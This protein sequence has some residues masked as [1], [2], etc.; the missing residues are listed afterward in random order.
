MNKKRIKLFRLLTVLMSLAMLL[1]SSSMTVLA[2][3]VG[4]F[5]DDSEEIVINPL[6]YSYGNL[7]Y[8]LDENGNAVITGNTLTEDTDLTIPSKIDGHNVVSIGGSAF[9]SCE[10][11]T[12]IT[13]PEGVTSIGEG[14]F[15]SCE[16]LTSINLPEGVTRIE[17]FT[18]A[19]CESLTSISMPDSVESIGDYAFQYCT[20]LTSINLPEGV[21]S[22]GDFAFQGCTNLTSINLPKRVTSIGDYAFYSC[23]SL[24]SINLPE[25]VTRIEGFTFADCESLKS[26]SMPDSVESIGDYAFQNCNSLTSITISEG[27]TSIGYYAFY[28]CKSLTSI[29][30]PEGVTSI[31]DFAFQGCTN[32]T[33]INLP[34]GVTRIEGS[35]FAYCESLT[36][37]SMP[38]SVESIGDYAF[39]NCNSLTSI[40]ISEGVTSI[41][42]G[43]FYCCES[44]TS[45]NLPEGVT[46]IEGY[47]FAY[48][49]SLTSISMPEGVTSI[50]ESAF[51]GCKSLTSISIPNGVTS[52]ESFTFGYCDNLTSITIPE[53]VNSIEDYAFYGDYNL[54]IHGTKGSYAEEWANN[55]GIKFWPL[56]AVTEITLNKTSIDLSVNDSETLT[57]TIKPDDATNKAVNWTST[58][59]KVATVDA[60]G[61]V[62]AVGTGSAEITV[63]A[64]DECGA[65]AT[66][67]VTVTQ[68]VTKIT[69]NKTS[70]KIAINKSETLT[71]TVKPDNASDK[72]VNW[73]STN[74]KVATVDSAG[75]VTAVGVGSATITATAADGS[76]V[77]ATCKVTVTQP[78]TK[79]TL[80]KTSLDL[81]VN[82]SE[83]LTA[84]VNPNNASNKAV[85]W[86]SS[87]TKVA[88]VDA[89][90]L[91]KAVGVGSATITATA[92]DGSGVKATC[93]VTVTQP[94][95]EITLN[96]A[97]L[98][99]LVNK[100]ETLKATVKPDNA[101]NKA[102]K[103]SS[104]NTKV[105]TVDSAGKVTAV[106]VGS[107]TITATAADG[108]G[109]KATCKVTVTQPVTKIT[110]NK[111]S[112]NLSVNKSE[113]L[114]ATVKPDNATNKAV[115]W[116]STNT[117]V[118]TVDANGL[119]KAVGA[120]SATITATAADGS[121]VKATCEV[122]VVKLVSEITLDK[123]DI[124]IHVG[125][126]DTINATVT[127]ADASNKEITWTSTNAD[128]A[129][130][131][132]TGKVTAVSAGT[133][134]ITATATDESG[135]S[136]SATV[137]VTKLVTDVFDD[138]KSTDWF[139]KS[140][141]YVYDHG[142]M[143]GTNGG[144]SF[145]P[146]GKLTR[147]QFTQVLYAYEGKPEVT[148]MSGFSDV[149]P[150]AWYAKSV[151]WAKEKGI[152]GGKPDGTF[153]VNENISRQ[154]LAVMLYTYAKIKN[155]DL[156][157]N[158]TALDNFDDKGKVSNYAKDAM[159]WAVTQG[160][161]SGKGN[162]KVDPIGN[163][164]RAECATMIM[165]L[166]EKNK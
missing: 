125:E 85:K 9:Y 133:A 118:A 47:T 69:L 162:G 136:A 36:S 97:S 32:L 91:V 49:K 150:K 117:K 17:G 131:D 86:S 51:Y 88:T 90:G 53:S 156:T 122:T 83:T 61:L 100:S 71:A 158:D 152:T 79:I 127:P 84:T 151:Y 8:E 144:K 59:T 160:V 3:G 104:S 57:A 43:A 81:L 129:T 42:E 55:N 142:I 108:S 155:Y 74:T 58:N 161:I 33:S 123:T 143:A 52:I 135:I 73:S 30:L 12:S 44:L 99:L 87:N 13:I 134:T 111:T 110:L 80:N 75:K 68:P 41:G 98:N 50:G 48:C 28:S 166:I 29:N 105:A 146:N 1:N 25:G 132:S 140:V 82:K 78:V 153:G 26:I 93:K 164:T 63:T 46:R 19:Y 54:A 130:V 60:N 101:S 120:G 22:I 37:I 137:K 31:G 113:T 62:K 64:A 10:S 147:E 92:A 18:F 109:V 157:K 35:T 67:E 27:V 70:L 23:E 20:N 38:D 45:I 165:K 24:T 95:T 56:G 89:N 7:I 163:A 72:A 103:W 106:G 40:T 145:S 15:Y 21:T 94:V 124:V 14:A 148:K 76:G 126:S 11:L 66:C 102:V 2:T 115:N 114:K 77:K 119:V 5:Y 6:S 116:K 96:K 149:D 128:A 65:I 16:S 4:D 138:V 107:A 112:L 139:V 34:E 154:D 141:Q 121:G 39:Q 159:K